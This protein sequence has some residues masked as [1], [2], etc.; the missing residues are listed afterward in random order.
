MAEPDGWGRLLMSSMVLSRMSSRLATITSIS[1]NTDFSWREKNKKLR[2][3]WLH[4]HINLSS[5]KEG[6]NPTLPNT[7]SKRLV[8][9]TE[10]DL[11]YVTYVNDLLLQQRH[12][13]VHSLPKSR[14]GSGCW[15]HKWKVGWRPGK[16]TRCTKSTSY[17][18]TQHVMRPRQFASLSRIA[19]GK[20]LLVPNVLNCLDFRLCL[21]ILF[22]SLE[23]QRSFSKTLFS[24][25]DYSHKNDF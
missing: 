25:N 10:L 5:G 18:W 13:E 2:K 7:E 12:R 17:A 8:D 23:L 22:S 14:L 15:T 11:T 24:A 19:D 3:W 20:P 6:K 9:L 21:H 1:S 16:Q 4:I